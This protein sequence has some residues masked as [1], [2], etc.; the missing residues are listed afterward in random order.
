MLLSPLRCSRIGIFLCAV[1]MGVV[2]IAR[3]KPIIRAA[4][5][6]FLLTILV[7]LYCAARMCIHLWCG[8][9]MVVVAEGGGQCN[10]RRCPFVLSD[11]PPLV[12]SPL[13]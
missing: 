13:D 10:A 9:V 2:S 4:S 6:P 8:V 11:C 5:W 7:G 1:L 12:F 3:Q